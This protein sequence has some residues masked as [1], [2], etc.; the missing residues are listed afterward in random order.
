[1]VGLSKRDYRRG[2]QEEE[3]KREAERAEEL[4]PSPK[5]P[6][7]PVAHNK[8]TVAHS[9]GE[10]VRFAQTQGSGKMVR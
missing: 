5:S 3:R 6:E 7:V 2:A 8:A 1:M 9:R 10:I 4:A